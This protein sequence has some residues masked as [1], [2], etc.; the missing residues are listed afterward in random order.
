MSAPSRIYT[1]AQLGFTEI[2][3]AVAKPRLMVSIAAP[4]KSGKT[5]FG[6]TGPGDIAFIC[7]DS[8]TREGI[9]SWRKRNPD[10]AAKK[11]IYMKEFV[12]AKDYVYDNTNI[13]TVKKEV[14]SI[15]DAIAGIIQNQSV[16]TV[17]IDT[18]T[19][20][21]ELF[22]LARLG[23]LDKVPQYM[24]GS[25]N[26]EYVTMM[27]SLNTDR[28]GL[29]S[30]LISK[31]KKQWVEGADGKSRQ[32]GK[33]EPARMDQIQFEAA[34]IGET[35]K[36]LERSTN[37]WVFGFRALDSGENQAEVCHPDLP[38][39]GDDCNFRALA[40]RCFPD[41]DYEYWS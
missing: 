8:R 9:N 2:T 24:Y 21:W 26:R 20:L 13:D 19:E 41:T 11:K 38:F 36:R 37:E 28:E 4:E 17:I 18:E 16:R 30:M 39:E 12:T 40:V 1:P 6:C 31:V 33:M 23:K 35:Y 25:L 14:Q 7:C 5:S 32:T 10:E 22:R 29:N 3:V 34:V 27:R 15:K